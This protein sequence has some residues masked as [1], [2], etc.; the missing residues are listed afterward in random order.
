LYQPY[1]N[2]IS[3]N[4]SET[5]ALITAKVGGSITFLH[6]FSAILSAIII[7]FSLILTLIV[8]DP[9]TTIS[10]MIFFGLSYYLIA[11]IVKLRLRLAGEIRSSQAPMMIKALQE[12]LGG[13]RN[14]ILDNNQE[15]YCQ[16]F[17]STEKK[18]R[19][20]NISIM[21]ISSAP[22]Y[23]LEGLGITFIVFFAYFLFS[24]G[25]ELDTLIPVLGALAI[26]AQRI[27]P[28]LHGVY[29]SWTTIISSEPSV[30]GVLSS[31]EESEPPNK[32]DLLVA[33]MKF[34]KCIQLNSVNFQY[35]I[36]NS[37]QLKNINLTI[38]KGDKIGIIG[39]TGSGKSTL[40]DILMGLLVP[41]SGQIFID[42]I[43]I[44]VANKV[45][46]QMNISH[47]PQN[48][49]LVDAT[50]AENIAL[51]ENINEIDINR[52]KRA[53]EGAQI[54]SFVESKLEGYYTKVGER[55]INLS[56]GQRQ[57]LALARALYKNTP[58]LVLD[59]A[60]SA[61]DTKTE[62]EVMEAIHY[63]N[64]EITVIIVTHR[65]DSLKICNIIY[66]LDDGCILDNR[67]NL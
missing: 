21:L 29:S 55:G 41:T 66:N 12:G 63:L 40:L 31:L 34:N 60:T 1:I 4:S 61:L 56:G 27:L 49:F 13:I 7:I 20:A 9:V 46:W 8:I 59:E 50:V 36:H 38:E 10:S 2:H 25:K 65:L 6:Q 28:L 45:S 58:I 33:P 23:L 30:S 24:S 64:S 52:V 14:V 17:E 3:K 51:G 11:L 62:C 54:A 48:I 53:A 57:R 67:G 26:G 15:F 16:L 32:F 47:V 43:E 5:L 35:P 37:F 42:G 44:T 19:N 39:T 22:R 18:I